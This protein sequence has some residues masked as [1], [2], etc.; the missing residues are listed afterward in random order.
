MA[1]EYKGI[2]SYKPEGNNSTPFNSL[3]EEYDNLIGSVRKD[4][5]KW[6][7]A[8]SAIL[9]LCLIEML[10]V[11]WAINLP[12]SIPYVIE[13]APW[14]EAKYVG[15]IGE[16][17]AG[18]IIVGEQSIKY[19]IRKTIENIRNIPTDQIVLSNNVEVAYKMFTEKA[20][21]VITNMFENEN[22]FA[23][24]G[25]LRREALIE[26]II[27]ITGSA[28]Q[29][30]WIETEYNI[31]NGQAINSVRM[32]AIVTIVQGEPDLNYKTENPLGI[33]I[34][35]YQQQEL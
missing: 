6:Q 24:F 12:K 23:M 13:V 22:T 26:S 21:V 15:D 19:Y 16:E 11:F 18:G 30:D 28:W 7:K 20:A 17:Q 34:D 29:I 14:G 32:R 4:R 3:L 35:S 5:E 10:V 9:V 25:L 27:N 1:N 8:F 33:Y 31:N 2:K